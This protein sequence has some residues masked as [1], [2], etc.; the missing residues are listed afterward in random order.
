MTIENYGSVWQIDHCLAIASF[1]LLDENDMKN[2]FNW[3]NLRPM[4]V[5]DNFIEGDKIYYHLYLLQEVKAKYFLKLN[6]YQ[7]GLN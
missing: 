2:C 1:N 6:N 5:K 7:Q 4:Y 3:N